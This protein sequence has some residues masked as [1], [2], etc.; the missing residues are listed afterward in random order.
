MNDTQSPRRTVRSFVRRQGRMTP[1]QKS[2]IASHADEHMVPL[3]EAYL[4]FSSLYEKRDARLI[5]EI[6]FGMGEA[7]IAAA[8]HEPKANY[9]GIEVHTPGVGRV[10]AAI[11]SEGLQNVKVIA[12]DAMYVLQHMLPD[13]C[14]SKIC[15]FFPDPW[16]KR[17]HQK[18][19]FLRSEILPLLHAKLQTAG[20]FHMA[21]D[22]EDYAK[23]AMRLLESS[24]LWKNSIAP[25][26]Y[27]Q[28]HERP[29]TRFEQRG[30]RLGHG[31][32]DLIFEKVETK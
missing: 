5:L 26:T 11:E 7:L 12:G 13:A 31:V 9:L 16:P 1:A 6:G 21:T 4:D 32:W 28:Q 14:L 3:Q 8:K 15:L 2:A 29:A 10:L 17:K 19:R 18:R 25:Y 20:L 30:R 27:A 24:D 22:W 23:Q